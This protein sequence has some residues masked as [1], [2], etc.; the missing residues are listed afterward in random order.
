MLH[1][2]TQMRKGLARLLV[3][4]EVRDD[5]VT[6]DFESF[7]I[8]EETRHI[9]QQVLGE[10]LDLVGVI[11]QHVEI[12]FR[13]AGLDRCQPH[14]PLD[15]A[16]QGAMLVEREIMGGPAAQ[17]A[18]DVV[19]PTLRGRLR[20][21]IGFFGGR[22]RLEPRACERVRDIGH[23]KHMVHRAR[24]NGAPWHS[25][26]ARLAWFLRDDQPAFRL[27]GRCPR[28]AI[29][30]GSRQDHG[31]GARAEFCGHGV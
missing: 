1:P 11:A 25:V 2:A 26:I 28:A 16:L 14:A 5:R 8:A 17:E 24:R 30:P 20:R 18:D 27:D 6:Q 7:W 19:Q 13:V 10:S 3:A 15:T 9:D 29:G 4:D 21:G 12:A 23:G 31:D 22:R